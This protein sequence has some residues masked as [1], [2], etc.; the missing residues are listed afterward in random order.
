MEQKD[1][2]V[3]EIEGLALDTI[4]DYAADQT[5]LYFEN[6][7]S[8]QKNSQKHISDYS[9]FQENEDVSVIF[10]TP[11]T[12]YQVIT[13]GKHSFTLH[14]HDF[15]ELNYIYQGSV[16]NYL[17]D[18]S[19]QQDHSKILLMNPF[20]QHGPKINTPDT[21]LFNII[22]RKEISNET[23]NHPALQGT[24]LINSFLNY[25]LG[26]S[27]LQSYLTFENTPQ[28]DL[29]LHQ[30]ILEFYQHKEFYQQIL[31]S[32]II[33]LWTLFARQIQESSQKD[34]V[35]YTED[36][37]QIL[38]YIQ[39]HYAHVTLGEVAKKFGFSENYLS[40]YIQKYTGTKFNQIVHNFKLQN[41][42]IY[43]IHSNLSLA[44]IAEI[45]GYNDINYFGKVFRREFGVSPGIY[46]NQHK[47]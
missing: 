18:G 9:L 3:K 46:R 21:I 23:T 40:K 32:K 12:K 35:E 25:S 29:L 5:R 38:A 47:S 24:Y 14:N 42:I 39:K 1:Y 43:L 10:H 27:P 28:I 34:N 17:L 16:T 36:I 22:I 37:A 41:A 31:Y 2:F 33:E 7:L 45:V 44:E 13:P 6:C 15:Y 4:L 8:K 30:I 26:L 19:I 20:C 11:G